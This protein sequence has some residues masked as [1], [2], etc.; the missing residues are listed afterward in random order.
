MSTEV[1]R[2][3]L[4]LE[5]HQG[6][7]T[8]QAALKKGNR[9][10]ESLLYQLETADTMMGL[11]FWSFGRPTKSRRTESNSEGEAT[12]I[13][14]MWK[15][16]L[17]NQFHDVLPGTSIPSVSR[18]AEQFFIDIQTE[19]RQ[20][21][22]KILNISL[23]ITDR[24][25]NCIRIYNL[26]PF[27]FP[28]LICNKGNSQR[29]QPPKTGE[30][31][32]GLESGLA[33]NLGPSECMDA[34]LVS[35]A[36]PCFILLRPT[37]ISK[38]AASVQEFTSSQRG[39][40]LKSTCALKSLESSIVLSNNIVEVAIDKHTG[41]ITSYCDCTCDPPVQLIKDGATSNRFSIHP[42]VPFFWDAWDLMVR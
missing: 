21:L 5:L 36:D 22:C 33:A 3:E 18:E 39:N 41:A 2:G 1:W 25:E 8:S 20:L 40:G 28:K 27:P 12:Q 23:Q 31:G 4:Y 42:D 11:E 34:P 10:G 29:I 37:G 24:Y 15:K 13:T 9:H 16:L 26:L 19:G 38:V 32:R 6:T 14:S 30:Y 35:I 7:L 17:L